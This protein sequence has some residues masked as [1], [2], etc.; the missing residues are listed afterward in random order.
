MDV[1]LWISNKK[2]PHQAEPCP[3]LVGTKPW[4]GPGWGE[5]LRTSLIPPSFH[6]RGR[7]NAHWEIRVDRHSVLLC[8]QEVGD[9]LWA[10]GA[11][12]LRSMVGYGPSVR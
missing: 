5:H 6:C 10:W 11:Q 4:A 1:L 3:Q 12:M 8:N 7:C 2:M 9:T